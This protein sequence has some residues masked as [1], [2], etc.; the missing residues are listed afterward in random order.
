MLGMPY[1]PFTPTFPWLG[2]LG[3]LPLPTKWR[4]I[5]GKPIQF[6]RYGPKDAENEK[7][8]AKV[9]STVRSK[10]QKMVDDT[11]DKRESIW[12]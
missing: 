3:G 11:L 6:S 8:V 1:F 10:I 5:F 2:P 9:S 4:I 12:Y 7:L